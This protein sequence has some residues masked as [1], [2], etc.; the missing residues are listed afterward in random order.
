MCLLISQL[1]D[2]KA[3][4]EKGENGNLQYSTVSPS[5]EK[6]KFNVLVYKMTR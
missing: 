2:L 6:A 4:F 3:V 1:A 5:A